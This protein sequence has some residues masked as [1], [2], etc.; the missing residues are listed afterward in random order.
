MLKSY[1]RIQFVSKKYDQLHLDLDLMGP[2]LSPVCLFIHQEMYLF[3]ESFLPQKGL[4]CK[5]ASVQRGIRPRRISVTYC[6]S[7]EIYS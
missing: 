7:S 1:P 4:L 3:P 2:G 6:V 5:M